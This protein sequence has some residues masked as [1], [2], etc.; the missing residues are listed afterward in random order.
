MALPQSPISNLQLT[1]PSRFQRLQWEAELLGFPASGHPLE[2]HPDIAWDT[3]CPVSRLGEFI[4]EEVGV[5]TKVFPQR[6]G[7]REFVRKGLASTKRLHLLGLVSPGGVHSHQ[8]HL[9]GIVAQAREEGFTDILIHAML[10]GRDTD[11]HSGLGYVEQLQA[12]LAEIGAGEERP[13]DVDRIAGTGDDR[14]VVV[15]EQHPHQV[16]EALLGADRVDHR[17]ISVGILHAIRQTVVVGVRVA[18]V[19]GRRHRVARRRRLLTTR[20]AAARPRGRVGALGRIRTCAHG[21]GG[22]CSI[23]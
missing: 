16:A 9:Y 20:T 8:E 22:R 6:E 17:A 18:R 2:L 3:Y 14:R 15:T 10:D 12:K 21:S 19:R 13:V 7:W 1:E 23:R 5:D 11:P 4:G